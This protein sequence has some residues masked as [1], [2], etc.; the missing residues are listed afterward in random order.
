MHGEGEEGGSKTGAGKGSEVRSCRLTSDAS[1]RPLLVILSR[2][3]SYH[4]WQ[5]AACSGQKP[6]TLSNCLP[7]CKRLK[8]CC[9][10][11][12]AVSKHCRAVA[13]SVT[14]TLVS[15]C[16]GHAL[17]VRHQPSLVVGPQANCSGITRAGDGRSSSHLMPFDGGSRWCLLRGI[18][19][20]GSG[21]RLISR[22][23]G[24]LA[25]GSTC[26][27]PNKCRTNKMRWAS[28]ALTPCFG[29]I[30]NNGCLKKRRGFNS[31]SPL[32]LTWTM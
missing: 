30:C 11:L 28:T 20:E 6:P 5:F 13:S 2:V 4:T 27:R 22:I 8:S 16:P 25:A 29:T 12:T 32:M 18:V 17:P 10:T 19:I 21:A 14:I 7:P 23:S 26:T 24:L 1:T 31:S 15:N 3:K 9:Q